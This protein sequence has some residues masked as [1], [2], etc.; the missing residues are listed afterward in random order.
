MK[1]IKKDIEALLKK[2]G[3]Y[4]LNTPLW[5]SFRFQQVKTNNAIERRFNLQIIESNLKSRKGV[6]IYVDTAGEVLY[7]GKG[8][9]LKSRIKSHYNKL[10]MVTNNKRVA[11]FQNN[12]G[13]MEIFWLE[14]EE[15]EE[16]EIV[17]HLLSYLLKPKYK[18]WR[19]V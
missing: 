5:H 11:F 7:I 6:Y 9:P 15:D 18:K 14:I 4:P 2:K 10:S 8:S 17:E 13:T 19:A 3:Y 1:F 16:R 12:Q